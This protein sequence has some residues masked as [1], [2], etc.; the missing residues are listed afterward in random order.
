MPARDHLLRTGAS[1]ALDALT[2]ELVEALRA[3]DVEPLLLKGP[4]IASRLYDDGSFRAH[5]DIDLLVAP[6]RHHAAEAVLA[7][8]GF[9]AA[10]SDGRAE[11]WIRRADGS[12]VDLHTMLFGVGVPSEDL[13]RAL[14][15]ETEP[16]RLRG[17]EVETLASH[18]L[19]LLVALHAAQHGPKFGKG[20][21]DLAR[22]LDRFDQ[23]TW[24]R[25]VALAARLEAV[26]AL[27]AGLSLDPRG[28]ALADRLALEAALTPAIALGMSSPPMVAGGVQ[29]LRETPG[30]RARARLL[31]VELVPTP[32][33]LR[34]TY[35]IA[36][37]GRLG[38]AAAYAW[39]P[40]WLAW[41]LP[42]AIRAV[43]RAD[44]A[45]RVRPR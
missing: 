32:A 36:G 5:D 45:A 8:L 28:A 10:G 24:T 14:E 37:R 27:A 9:E 31:A 4:A 34:A 12:V 19:A 18:A 16:L 25:A 6:A 21:D 33:F 1:L 29:R 15:P 3:R 41:H 23:D 22:A 20:L 2:A 7:E 30:I 42:A 39:R 13:W 43:R 44:R 11:P 26:P 35:A 17:V 40:L 38:L